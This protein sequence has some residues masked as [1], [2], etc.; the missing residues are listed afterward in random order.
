MDIKLKF[1]W[2]LDDR[3]THTQIEPVLFDLLEAIQTEGSLKKAT[4]KVTVSYRYAWGMLNKWQEMFGQPLVQMSRG[5]GTLLSP[6]GEKLMN[7]NR[8]LQANYAPDLANFATQL[9]SEL[10]SLIATSQHD[11]LNIFASHGLAISALR[12]VI[13][14][15]TDFKLDLHFHGSL[16]SLRAMQKNKCHIAG[17]HIPEGAVGQSIKDDYLSYLSPDKHQLIYV[18]KRN[19]GLMVAKH[20]PKQVNDIASLLNQELRFVNRH[21]ESGTRMLLDHYLADAKIDPA[22]INGYL[23]EEYTHMAVAAMVASGAADVGFGIAPIADK[24]NLDFIPMVWEHYCLAVPIELMEDDRV[25]QTLKL[26]ASDTF[27]QQLHNLNG[28]QTNRA[29]ERVSFTEIFG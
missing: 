10:I 8:Q 19:Q 11:G 6:V 22:N 18:I 4:D 16:E 2:Q 1:S 14:Q 27:K 24:F 17:F 26:L 23:H 29:G 28:Y 25:K 3:D 15:E 5:Q 21:K 12:E 7:A 13:T 20:N 9:R